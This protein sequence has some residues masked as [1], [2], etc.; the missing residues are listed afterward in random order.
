MDSILTSIFAPST[1]ALIATALAIFLIPIFFHLIFFRSRASRTLPTFVLL[2]PVGSGKTSIVTSFESGKPQETRTSQA[3]LSLECSIA[4]SSISSSKYRSTNDPTLK[5]HKRF[6]LQDTPGHGKLRDIAMK[7]VS[8]P[9]VRGTVFVVDSSLTDVRQTA[10]YLYDVLL[11]LQKMV[12]SSTSGATKKLL[13]ACNKSDL[14][15]A[16]PAAKIQ[17]LL[18][19]EITKIRVSRSKGLLDVEEDDEEKEWLGEGGEGPFEFKGMEDVGVDID[20]RGGSV[21]KGEWTEKLAQWV[22]ECL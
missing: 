20:V 12:S 1:P 7:H 11:A 6:L 14:F 9:A 17:K 18:E 21:E 10:E 3:P 4:E 5:G 15:T 13:I 8:S 22:G 19:E 2:G 16:L